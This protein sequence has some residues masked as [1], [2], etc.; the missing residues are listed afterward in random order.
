MRNAPALILVIGLSMIGRVPGLQAAAVSPQGT[1]NRKSLDKVYDGDWWLVTEVDE[2]HAFLEGID[3]CLVW[4]AHGKA[5]PQIGYEF[6]EK[7][8]RY[9]KAHPGGR[10]VPVIDVWRELA[11]QPT[12]PKPTQGGE[13]WTNPHWDLNGLYWR[14][15]N[16]ESGRRGFL[17]GYLW[18]LRTCVSKPTELYSRPVSYYV[19]QVSNYIRTHPKTADDEAIA[20]ILS[21]FRDGPRKNHGASGVPPK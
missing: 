1:D 16:Y 11:P 10:K 17:E 18:C 7:I 14:Q 20:D 9:Y 12:S 19:R 15:L 4:S 3:D 21:R 13:V 5:L 8:T 2:R 6:D